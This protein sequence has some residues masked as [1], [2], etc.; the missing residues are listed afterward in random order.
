M[1]IAET[2]GFNVVYN[3]LVTGILR[4]SPA[5]WAPTPKSGAI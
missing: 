5:V 2:S 3:S 4:A 1:M